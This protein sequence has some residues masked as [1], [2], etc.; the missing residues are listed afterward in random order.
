MSLGRSAPKASTSFGVDAAMAAGEE[1]LKREEK[2][3]VGT[4]DNTNTDATGMCSCRRRAED[5]C[6][7]GGTATGEER[8]G[9]KKRT[10]SERLILV[11][12]PACL[13][14]LDMWLQ[15]CCVRMVMSMGGFVHQ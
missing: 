3:G 13:G 9:E 14:P 6:R 8:F 11:S 15:S 2:N 7:R 4:A 10:I 5:E 1:G 12:Q